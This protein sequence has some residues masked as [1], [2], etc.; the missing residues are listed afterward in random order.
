M[1]NECKNI[2]SHPLASDFSIIQPLNHPALGPILYLKSEQMRIE[3][4]VNK[5]QYA[6]DHYGI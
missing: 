5:I 6:K 4:A 3:K 1:G 2:Q